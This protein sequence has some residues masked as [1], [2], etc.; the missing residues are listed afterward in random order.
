MIAAFPAIKAVSKKPELRR[1]GYREYFG[2]NYVIVYRVQEDAVYLLRL[3]HQS[4]D[5]ERDLSV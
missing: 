4:Q 1:L 5:Y 3:F 2:E